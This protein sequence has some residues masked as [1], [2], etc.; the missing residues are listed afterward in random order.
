MDTAGSDEIAF[1]VLRRRASLARAV[2]ERDLE[3]EIVKQLLKRADKMGEKRL[4]ADALVARAAHATLVGQNDRARLAAQEAL[5]LYAAA[6][7][8]AGQLEARCRLV[9][10]GYQG[11]AFELVGPLLAEARAAA[12]HAGS[13]APLARAINTATHVAISE[14]R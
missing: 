11:G 3:G 8:A 9:E 12:E 14:Q 7:D 5:D 2:G 4:R 13:P 6:G 10:T 1:T